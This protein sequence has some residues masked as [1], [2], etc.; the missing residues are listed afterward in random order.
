[1]VSKSDLGTSAA[2]QQRF[3]VVVEALAGSILAELATH[4]GCEHLQRREGH[5]SS[6]LNFDSTNLQPAITDSK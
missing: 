2:N 5:D 4:M 3:A 1:M 6:D